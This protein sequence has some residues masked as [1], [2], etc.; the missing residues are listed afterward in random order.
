[1]RRSDRANPGVHTKGLL[2]LA[3]LDITVILRHVPT[4]IRA[5][6]HSSVRKEQARVTDLRVATGRG[7]RV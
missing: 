7:F 6:A 5:S 1:M 4:G 2:S 3:L